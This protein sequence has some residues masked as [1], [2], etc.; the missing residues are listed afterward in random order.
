MNEAPAVEF[1]RWRAFRL[2]MRRRFEAAHGSMDDREG[3]AIEIVDAGGRRGCGEASPMPSLGMGDVADVLA[4]LEEHG[5]ALVGLDAS[6]PPPGPGVSSLRC[7][8]DVATLDLEGQ[9]RGVPV[10]ALLTEVPAPW[11]AVNAVIGGGPPL[12]VAEHGREAM[13]HGYSVLKLK[14]GVA[15]VAEDEERVAA[16]RAACPEATIRLDANGAWDEP[17]AGEAI[18]AVYPHR[19]E[20]L[21]Q[22]VPAEDVE[23]LARIREAAPLRIAADEAVDDPLTL[24]RLLELRAADVLVLK[25]MM[26]GGVRAALDVARRAYEAGINAYAT[27]TFDSSIGTVASLHL[28]AALP[29]DAA[30]GLATGEHLGADI[31]ARTVRP[32]A[33]RLAVPVSPGL[34]V[35]LDD[36][37]LDA[38]ATAPWS[39]ARR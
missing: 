4:L 36:G 38:V 39:E 35:A 37:A 5:A 10:T 26:L 29:Q 33:G 22:P 21:E 34:G 32:R 16:L 19:I 27:T 17:T 28:A 3:V 1:I 12:E 14:V 18:D 15:G 11:V 8:L 31:V 25:P 13:E 2:P 24:E 7:A 9:R 30:H 23:A 20:L 6:T